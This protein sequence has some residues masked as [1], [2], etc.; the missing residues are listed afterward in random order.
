MATSA[1]STDPMVIARDSILAPSGLDESR[2]DTVFG[3]L[4]SHAVDYADLYFQFV[5]TRSPGRWRTAS[6]RKA[7]RPSSRAWACAR[8]SGEKTGFA[9]SDEICLLALEDASR[10]RARHR[11]RRAASARWPQR[12]GRG[13]GSGCICRMIRSRR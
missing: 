1:P 11:R 3:H 2:L 5:R 9:Y 4:M 12:L 13:A 6:S 10:R 7:A 8:S